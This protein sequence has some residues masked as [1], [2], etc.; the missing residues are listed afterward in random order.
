MWATVYDNMLTKRATK[1]TKEVHSDSSGLNCTTYVLS[2]DKEDKKNNI[3]GIAMPNGV[4]NNNSDENLAIEIVEEEKL[5]KYPMIITHN[6]KVGR[7]IYLSINLLTFTALSEEIL[8]SFSLTTNF[9]AICDQAVGS[10]TIPCIHG[11]RALSMA[12]IILG[13]TCI[14]SFKYSDNMELRKVVEQSFFF[15]T[16]SNGAFSVDTFFFISGFLVSFLYFR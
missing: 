14:I 4:N 3:V 1:F 15:Q 11:I 6:N 12:W 7:C 5:C 2:N 10:D 16:I 8:L 9:R 13:H